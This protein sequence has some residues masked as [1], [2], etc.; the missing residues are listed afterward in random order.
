MKLI[1][2][3][4]SQDYCTICKL[5]I[6]KIIWRRFFL[7]ESIEGGHFLQISNFCRYIPLQLS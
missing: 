1:N 4:V 7:G 3:G 6:F 5:Q 2:D